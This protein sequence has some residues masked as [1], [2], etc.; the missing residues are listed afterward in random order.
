M[1]VAGQALLNPH[2]T[3]FQSDG[4]FAL[5]LDTPPGGTLS[6]ESASDVTRW[7]LLQ[8]VT[9]TTTRVN[10]TDPAVSG[11]ANRSYRAKAK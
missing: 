11:K 2:R 8:A 10:I 3:A 1:R 4:S 6:I 5:S 9:N 7:S